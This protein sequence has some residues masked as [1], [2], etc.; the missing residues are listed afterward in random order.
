MYD[1]EG[2]FMK[3]RENYYNSNDKIT[4]IYMYDNN[5]ILMNSTINIYKPDNTIES[6]EKTTYDREGKIH[7]V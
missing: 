3:K 6:I 5:H 2:N 1:D 7:G 4:A